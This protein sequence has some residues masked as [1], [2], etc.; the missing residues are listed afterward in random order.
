MSSRI[1]T[2]G[3]NWY[4]PLVS[5]LIVAILVWGFA[6]GISQHTPVAIL[7]LGNILAYMYGGLNRKKRPVFSTLRSLIL[8]SRYP[9][10]G[11][12]AITLAVVGILWIYRIEQDFTFRILGLLIFFTTVNH[13]M[14]TGNEVISAEPRINEISSG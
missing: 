6:E 13:C 14:D 2:P 8:H 7:G 11:V 10:I 5:M 9:W 1:N 12:M 3:F 4:W